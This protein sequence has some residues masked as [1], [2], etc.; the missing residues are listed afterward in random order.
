MPYKL[1]KS[2]DGYKVAGPSGTSY[3]K[4][5]QSRQQAAAQ[6]RALYA[7]EYRKGSKTS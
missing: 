5:P 7:N 2:G 4:H 3:S 1:V 6:M